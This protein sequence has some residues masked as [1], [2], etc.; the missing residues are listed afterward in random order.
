MLRCFAVVLLLVSTSRIAPA[1]QAPCNV[2]VNVAAEKLSY[3]VPTRFHAAKWG[4]PPELWLPARGLRPEDFVVRDGHHS[5]PVL[6]V[7]TETG[8]RRVVFVVAYGRGGAA[9]TQPLSIDAG[10]AGAQINVILSNARPEDSFGLLNAWGPHLSVPL[11]SSLDA[12]RQVLRVLSPGAGRPQGDAVLDA[13]REVSGWFGAPQ[14][15]DSI[16]LVGGSEHWPRGRTSQVCSALVSRGIRL[17]VLGAWASAGEC[18]AW[19]PCLE[20]LSPDGTLAEET[21]GGWESIGYRGPNAADENVWLWQNEAKS[22]YDMATSSY[23]LR[24]PKAGP[25][26][27]IELSPEGLSHLQWPP[28][29]SYPRPLPVCP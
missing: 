15:G 4:F 27:K 17:F 8:P 28:R 18:E 26:L 5:V 12:L 21:G 25:H 7:E 1:Q 20:S 13:L 9:A 10:P 23:V 6:S 19:L 14:A 16:F 24:L 22:L 2:P 29:I 3:P 11:G